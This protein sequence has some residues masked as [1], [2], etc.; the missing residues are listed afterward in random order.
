MTDQP[1]IESVPSEVAAVKPR[2]PFRLRLARRRERVR[3]E[4]VALSLTLGLALC[5][6]GAQ[7]HLA[8]VY[9]LGWAL[10]LVGSFARPRWGLLVL[11]GLVLLFSEERWQPF[12]LGGRSGAVPATIY[13]IH[14]FGLKVQWA[15]AGGLVAG[16]FLQ[17]GAL[18]LRRNRAALVSLC[19]FLA[20]D[21][22]GEIWGR[23]ATGF[24]QQLFGQWAVI[25]APVLVAIA[26]LALL[27][28]DDV[29][30]GLRILLAV[31]TARLIFGL[32]RYG[33]GGG[34]WDYELNRRIVF[35]DTADGFVSV[36]VTIGGLGLL[37]R[38]GPRWL[39]TRVTGAL[40]VLA[41]LTALALSLR[42]QGLL[43]LAVSAVVLT[44]LIWRPRRRVVLIASLAA[45]AVLLA[46][47]VGFAESSHSLLAARVRS[48][49][50]LD[51]ASAS[52][53]NAFHIEDIR[54][55]VLQV[56]ERPWTGW[57]FHTVVRRQSDYFLLLGSAADVVTAKHNMY[58]DVWLRMGVIGFVAL[59]AVLLVGCRDGL[60]ARRR[61]PSVAPSILM[62]LLAGY[63]V[64][65]LV[66]P[67]LNSNR[68]PYFLFMPV[69]ALTVLRGG[70]RG[71]AEG[72][73]G[74][75]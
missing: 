60:L 14:V 51:R 8:P 70:G 50:P 4:I 35:S 49:N 57:G 37:L 54:D 59:C 20:A 68:L 6:V 67:M 66:M 3:G 36:L 9:L 17:T 55:G 34:V 28:E 13:T 40:M 5:L 32:V 73:L 31:A 75:E 11:L 2:V 56:A 25:A 10:L 29:I 52:A 27:D 22:W 45:L 23:V 44:A 64:A 38:A 46:V 1:A 74:G 18:H 43:A 69:V 26:A 41:G 71:S 33:V 63:A 48:M 58:L 42:R 19:V 47:G 61:L 53:T 39:A 72:S 30:A 16:A 24:G 21:V 12:L 15:L 62:A 7:V 65:S